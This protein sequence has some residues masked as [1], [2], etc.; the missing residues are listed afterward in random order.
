[1]G[2]AFK[3][4]MV[5]EL[6]FI[7][8]CF[9][10]VPEKKEYF[11]EFLNGFNFEE[12]KLPVDSDKE[13]DDVDLGSASNWIAPGPALLAQSG[14]LVLAHIDKQTASSSDIAERFAKGVIAVLEGSEETKKSV[15]RLIDLV[16]GLRPQLGRVQSIIHLIR[17]NAEFGLE[18]GEL[19]KKIN[20]YL[21][22]IE[23]MRNDA[24][25]NAVE[26]L[27]RLKKPDGPLVCFLYGFGGPLW[28]T[29]KKL[30][31]KNK[32]DKLEQE[33]AAPENAAVKSGLEKI[34]LV[35]VTA[36]LRPVGEGGEVLIIDN[37][38]KDLASK[39]DR[40]DQVVLVP[41][42][43]INGVMRQGVSLD[44]AMHKPNFCLMGCEAFDDK[45]NVINSTGCRTVAVLAKDAGVPFYV[46]TE[47]DKLIKSVYS[48]QIGSVDSSRFIDGRYSVEASGDRNEWPIAEIVEKEY[49]KGIIT[50]KKQKMK[51][52]FKGEADETDSI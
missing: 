7:S 2:R 12:V 35:L 41:D 38:H 29:I 21:N 51:S 52:E 48:A 42:E 4:L 30:S 18:K 43:G 6:K 17:D 34:K 20:G 3:T 10:K 28:A 49:I 23:G 9:K 45:R 22:D 37:F 36:P 1:L 5:S 32:D 46:V 13:K 27:Y 15:N 16:N 44:G 50:E 14:L 24:V 25:S 8:H 19:A 11:K 47:S 31:E 26:V 33:K 39:T 40:N